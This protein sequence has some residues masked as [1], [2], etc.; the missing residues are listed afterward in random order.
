MEYLAT[1]FDEIQ[2]PE[3]NTIDEVATPFANKIDEVSTPFENRLDEVK[4][5]DNYDSNLKI[6]S[7]RNERITTKDVKEV[8][9]AEAIR[10]VKA[11]VEDWLEDYLIYAYTIGTSAASE[12]MN[13]EATPDINKMATTINND[14]VEGMCSWRDALSNHLD[15]LHIGLAKN[16]AESEFHRVYNT[17]ILDSAE[18]LGAK[19]KTWKTMMD[20]R[21]RET[22]IYLEDITVPINEEFFTYDGDHAMYPGGF[23][24]AE[25]NANCRCYVS[26]K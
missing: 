14:K 22:H 10:R 16:L 7:K 4:T 3:N 6:T 26:L 2:T 21:V 23:M 17:A 24:T 18:V 9:T 13:K 1:M 20:D 25:N 5:P 8:P 12:M 11:E 19:T 15:G